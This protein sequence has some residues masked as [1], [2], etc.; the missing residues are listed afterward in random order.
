MVKSQTVGAG[1]AAIYDVVVENRFFYDP[2]TSENMIYI[3]MT[4]L[5]LKRLCAN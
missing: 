1:Q 3:A 4:N 5:M 2:E